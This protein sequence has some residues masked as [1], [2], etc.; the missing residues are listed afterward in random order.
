MTRRSGQ[1]ALDNCLATIRRNCENSMK[2][3]K[4]KPEQVEQRMG[5]V[6]GTLSYD[7]FADADLVIEAMFENMDVK[8]TVFETLDKV[9]KPGAILASNTSYLNLDQIASFT[10]RPGDVIGLHF[11]SPANV[12]RLLEVVRGAQ[13][14]PDVLATSMAIAKTIKKT[15]LPLPSGWWMA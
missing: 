15:V 2:K 7:A 5:W 4:L 10:Q 11:F 1:E 13:T 12:M 9:C 14:A 3:G 6:T 8:K